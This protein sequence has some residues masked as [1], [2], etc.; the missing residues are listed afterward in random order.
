MATIKSGVVLDN[1]DLT[2]GSL[3]EAVLKLENSSSRYD[4]EKGFTREKSCNKYM[5]LL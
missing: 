3:E 5:E 1:F 2:S 4:W